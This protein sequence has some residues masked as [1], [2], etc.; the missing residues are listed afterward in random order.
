M[1]IGF[2]GLSSAGYGTSRREDTVA[3]SLSRSFEDADELRIVP[4]G[5]PDLSAA[6]AHSWGVYSVC[7]FGEAHNWLGPGTR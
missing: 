3:A 7:L 6:P 5:A 1:L 4:C 2:A